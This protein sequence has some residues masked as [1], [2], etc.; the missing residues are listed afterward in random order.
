MTPRHSTVSLKHGLLPWMNQDEGLVRALLEQA[1]YEKLEVQI[2]F[3]IDLI[4]AVVVGASIWGEFRHRKLNHA[5]TSPLA[6]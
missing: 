1:S 2:R 3:H 5:E 6:E 4:Y